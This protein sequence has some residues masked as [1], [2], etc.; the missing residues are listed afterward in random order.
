MAGGSEIV[1]A[2]RTQIGVPYS[3]VKI[4][5]LS[6]MFAYLYRSKI[7]WRWLVWKISR[8]SARCPHSRF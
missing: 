8:H 7:G 1:A 6:T 3:W 5:E 2:A 4:L